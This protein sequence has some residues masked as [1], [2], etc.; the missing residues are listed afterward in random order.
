[1]GACKLRL[2]LPFLL[3]GLRTARAGDLDVFPQETV[4]PQCSTQTV[5]WSKPHLHVQPGDSITLTNLVDLGV[6]NGS[7]TTFQVALPIGQSFSFAYNTLA[8]QFT[9]LQSSIMQ[10]GPGT[11]DCLVQQ[12][13]SSTSLEPGSNP[14]PSG[15]GTSPTATYVSSKSVAPSSTASNVI[16]AG[17]PESAVSSAKPPFP[18]GAVIGIVAAIAGAILIGLAL[19][20]QSHRRSMKRLADLH[21]DSERSL[22]S[23][24]GTN[25]FA[26]MTHRG[27]GPITPYQESASSPSKAPTKSMRTSSHDTMDL[28]V[29]AIVPQQEMKI[30]IPKARRLVL[31]SPNSPATPTTAMTSPRLHTDAGVRIRN[32]EEL[33]PMYYNYNSS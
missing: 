33:P 23:A 30:E 4:V 2:V 14:G 12:S 18:I 29:G 21:A 31:N 27:R 3:C 17:A 15:G 24:P 13:S 9:V 22:P 8:E 1:M 16:A 28:P 25:L 19:F 20:W 32:P 26:V 7:F 11:T 6:Q 10:V 5:L